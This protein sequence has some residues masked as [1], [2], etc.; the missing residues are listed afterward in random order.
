[1][2]KL[3][4]NV[5]LKNNV[6]VVKFD[7]YGVLQEKILYNKDD[8]NNYK[9]AEAVTINEVSRGGFLESFLASIREKMYAG[10]K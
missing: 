4:R 1:M 9:F 7:S 8:M 6:L 3:G 2:I 5:L 10:K